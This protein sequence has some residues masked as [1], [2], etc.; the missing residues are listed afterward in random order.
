MGREVRRNLP[1]AEGLL[2]VVG[3]H[4]VAKTLP[5]YCGVSGSLWRNGQRYTGSG[6]GEWRMT[7]MIEKVALA[8]VLTVRRMRPYFHN[9]SITI[10]THYPILKFLSKPNL[11]GRMIGWSI[12]LSKFDIRYELRGVVKFQCLVE[13]SI[14]LTPLSDLSI[15]WTLY[16]LKEIHKGVCGSHSSAW[17]MAAKV[18]K[19]DH[20]WLILQRDYVKYVKKCAKCQ[21]FG[22]LHHL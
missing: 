8:L 10:R 14:E 13:F 20:Y 6:G 18:L 5:I 19:V 22:P 15:G 11:A 16:V 21:E 9:H 7:S 17:T 2:V 3:N 12:E 4:P 1:T